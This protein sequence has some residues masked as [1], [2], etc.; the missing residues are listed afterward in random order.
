MPNELDWEIESFGDDPAKLLEIEAVALEDTSTF[1]V[2]GGLVDRTESRSSAAI[3]AAERIYRAHGVKPEDVARMRALLVSPESHANDASAVLA[4]VGR[5][6]VPDLLAALAHE[7]PNVRIR[8]VRSLN[9]NGLIDEAAGLIADPDPRV[10]RAVSSAWPKGGATWQEAL[11][12]A[13]E[14]AASAVRRIELIE[15]LATTRS[16][17]AARAL[18][19]RA[20]DTDGDVRARAAHR[21]AGFPWT[22]LADTPKHAE[23]AAE[24]VLREEEPNIVANLLRYAPVLPHA[25]RALVVLSVHGEATVRM[26][27]C[28]RLADADGNELALVRAALARAARDDGE[29]I[30]K[31]ARAALA[32]LK[33]HPPTPD[34]PLEVPSPWP[35]M[36]G[37]ESKSAV[38]ASEREREALVALASAEESVRRSALA[39]E[40]RVD[41]MSWW[42]GVLR[43]HLRPEPEAGV[44]LEIVSR[45][46][47]V[48]GS[49]VV[50]LL[51]DALA[52]PHTGVREA[53]ARCLRF[54]AG[55]RAADVVLDAL[56]QESETS[57]R[58]A[59]LEHGWLLANRPTAFARMVELTGD[60]SPRVRAGATRQLRNARFAAAS[61]LLGLTRDADLDVRRAA[62]E[63]LEACGGPEA[64]P[65]LAE[66]RD[67]PALAPL[68][69]KAIEWIEWRVT[70][71]KP[72]HWH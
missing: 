8:A 30:Q 37:L 32:K 35:A 57:V 58:A 67:E 50:E 27:A 14:C 23:H 28:E 19:G 40:P 1:T 20:A 2:E 33:D 29:R 39:F 54:Q 56:F 55:E 45:V 13:L 51:A 34:V 18:L 26:L 3:R 59:L 31:A 52:D 25:L 24:W 6:L 16:D 17:I 60:P 44:R 11:A 10:G 43:A 66:L 46:E 69:A 4:L 64:L 12:T 15:A 65:R 41:R 61:E 36:L 63:G 22:E 42:I 9:R 71:G 5:E 70:N 7:D 62:I 72:S 53:A 68:V 48:R 38:L 49:D 47:R 21:L